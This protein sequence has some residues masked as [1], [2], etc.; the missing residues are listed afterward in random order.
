MHEIVAAVLCFLAIQFVLV[1]LI[2]T[3]KRLLLPAGKVTILV[4]EEKELTVP[5]GGKLL[6]ALAEQNIFLSSACGGGGSCGQCRC[7]VEEGGGAILPT[8]L[9]SIKPAEARRGMR[10]SCQ[11]PVKRDLKIR[12]P[13]E[14]LETRK[15][16]CRVRSNRNVATFIKELVLELPPGEEVNFQPGG[17]IQIEVPPHALEYKSFDIDEKFLGDWTKFKMFQY[18]SR[19]HQPVSRAYSMANYPAEQGLIKLN[20]RI[21]SPPPRGPLSTPPGQASS[22]IFNLKEGDEVTI[23]GPFG[24]FFIEDS[25]SEMIYVGG[26]AGM[27]PLRSHIMELFKTR[28]TSRKV[29]FWY[30]SRSLREVFYA[31]EF[32]ALAREHDNFTFHLALSEPQPEDNWQGLTGFIHQVLFDNYLKDHPSPEDIDYYLCGPPVM[33]Q[34]MLTMLDD[35]GVEEANIHFDDFGG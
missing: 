26:G 18:Q 23:A 31:E 33:T 13:P 19:V 8:E 21:A 7:L 1:T 15:W 20:V 35:L 30:G 28:R 4:N 32:E 11:V 3:A 16:V 9:S 29:S 6:T 2:V 17:F 25:D 14:M 5:P 24:D 34:A 10:L 12:I 27:A 22:Y